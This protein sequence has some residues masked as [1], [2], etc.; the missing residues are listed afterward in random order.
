MKI[1]FI[2]T[3]PEQINSFFFNY[4]SAVEGNSGNCDGC[5]SPLYY[6]YV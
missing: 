2:A 6:M 5:Q 3:S 1:C 4:N